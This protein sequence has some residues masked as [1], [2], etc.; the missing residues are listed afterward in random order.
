M[1]TLLFIEDLYEDY[2]EFTKLFEQNGFIVFPKKEDIH[3]QIDLNRFLGKNFDVDNFNN[4]NEKILNA[5]KDKLFV[6]HKPTLNVIIPM[7][8]KQHGIALLLADDLRRHGHC[9]QVLLDQQKL[10]KMMRKAN[11]LGA[12]NVLI[13]GEE[14]QQSGTVTLKN[15]GSGKEQKMAQDEIHKHL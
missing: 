6:P 4:Y 5:I 3:G 15:M 13:L 14:E 10:Q 12:N 9:T 2:I 7:D 11:K 1:K 8:V